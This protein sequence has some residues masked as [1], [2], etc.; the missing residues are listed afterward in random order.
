MLLIVALV[1]L[2]RLRLSE[3]RMAKVYQFVMLACFSQLGL[4]VYK[5]P[6]HIQIKHLPS[7][8]ASIWESEWKPCRRH[9]SLHRWPIHETSTICCSTV[10]R[11]KSR[12]GDFSISTTR[13]SIN[14]L[15]KRG[16]IVDR[17]A[18]TSYPMTSTSM[19][20]TLNMRYLSSQFG[21]IS[22]YFDRASERSWQI[23]HPSRLQIPLLRKSIRRI[24]K[25]HDRTVEY[26]G[27]EV[28]E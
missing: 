10:M 6:G 20:S 4:R 13:S 28:A 8:P 5:E 9:G 19:A 17:K 15:E 23:V 12:S 27:L 24:A 2:F 16:F 11:A 22:D 3:S 25:E 21:N 7:V 26:E 14:E 1:V 18:I